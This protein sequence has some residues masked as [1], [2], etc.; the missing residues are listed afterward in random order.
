[1]FQFVDL[2]VREVLFKIKDVADICAAP[3]VNGLIVVADNANIPAV[4]GKQFH[5][6]VLG[7]IGILVFIHVDI[8]EFPL[9]IFQHRGMI[10]KK[11]KGTNKQV[12]KIQRVGSAK[13]FLIPNKN[14]MDPLAS[15]IPLGSPEPFIGCHHLVLGVRYGIFDILHGKCLFVDIQ[16]FYGFLDHSFSIVVIIDRKTALISKLFNVT[17]KDADADGMKGPHPH[18]VG[19]LSYKAGYPLLHLPGSLVGKGQRHD[20][21]RSH[22]MLHQVG[23]AICESPGFSASCTGQDQHRAF[24]RFRCF[25]LHWI[26]IIQCHRTPQQFSHLPP[27]KKAACIS[28]PLL[29][30]LLYSVVIL[31]SRKKLHFHYQNI[32]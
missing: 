3:S 20:V 2:R 30:S 4:L 13:L 18:I 26:Q 19:A 21:V 24:K 28:A 8:P 12:V 23:D 15:V 14:V 27:D 9:V 11:L 6:L 17:P 16:R 7:H 10:D 5:Q 32:H 29:L 31:F 1:M 22:A 25:S